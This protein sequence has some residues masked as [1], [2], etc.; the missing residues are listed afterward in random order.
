MELLRRAGDGERGRRPTD[1]TVLQVETL[2]RAGQAQP[3]G[4][5]GKRSETIRSFQRSVRT[6]TPGSPWE[7]HQDCC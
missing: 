4:K 5:T 3:R 2:G 1:R 6:A 7:S